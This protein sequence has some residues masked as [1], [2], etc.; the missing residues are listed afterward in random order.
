MKTGPKYKVCRRLGSNVFEKCQTQSY[1]LS[2][3]KH[4]KTVKRRRPQ[5]SDFARQL[6]EKQR[7]RFS[8]GIAERQLRRYV[9]EAGKRGSG[10]DPAN[11]MMG[12]LETRLDN[13]VFRAGLAKSRRAAR[14]LV[15]HGHITVN[16]RKMTIPSYQ[17]TE[18]D[19]IGVRKGSLERPYF[20]QRKEQFQEA[21]Q[22]KWLSFD[23]SQM[24]AK[25]VAIPNGE[26][27]ESVA[28]MNAVLEFYSR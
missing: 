26:N 5:P 16:D 25:L 28:D 7:I 10:I 15:A 19:I 9:E 23:A 13:I 6:I 20:A 11:R 8:Y 22:P 21:S 4:S 18:K 27:T 3:A 17:V 2:E 12:L 14:Q 1:V 24:S